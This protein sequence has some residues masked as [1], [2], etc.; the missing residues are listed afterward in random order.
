MVT[1]D[2]DGGVVGEAYHRGGVGAG[3]REMVFAVRRC[4]FRAH[5][6]G[7]APAF[8]T[9]VPR[10]EPQAWGKEGDVMLET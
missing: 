2:N 7:R 9:V 8:V 10:A 1:A 4:A 6:R 5:E 3:G